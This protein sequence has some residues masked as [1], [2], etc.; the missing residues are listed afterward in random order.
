MTTET[1]GGSS[2]RPCDFLRNYFV[3]WLIILD[4]AAN[5]A[6]LGNPNETIST[7]LG[8]AEIAGSKFGK[9]ACSVLNW[10]APNHCAW[11]ADPTSGTMATE[12]WSW[13]PSP[14]DGDNKS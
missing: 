7:R 14:E 4:K 2:C 12:L 11:S 6:L 8:R 13:N 1:N 9:V 3:N 10:F 5:T